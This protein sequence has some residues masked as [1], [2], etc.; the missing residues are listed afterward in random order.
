MS[1]SS[2]IDWLDDEGTGTGA[3]T[4][5][6]CMPAALTSWNS[7]RGRGVWNAP[8]NV[9]GTTRRRPA[10]IWPVRTKKGVCVGTDPHKRGSPSSE[11]EHAAEEEQQ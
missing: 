2:T 3:L 4:R 1:S 10:A 6:K 8:G 5:A 11:E 7:C 9:A